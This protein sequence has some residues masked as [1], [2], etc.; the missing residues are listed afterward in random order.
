MVLIIDNIYL[1]Y[2]SYLLNLDI[3]NRKKRSGSNM[4]EVKEIIWIFFVLV[5]FVMYF[6]GLAIFILGDLYFAIFGL[7]SNNERLF[8]FLGGTPY[9]RHIFY[10]VI[11]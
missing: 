9:T 7:T 1:L 10:E 2:Y 4:K 11:E 6:I 3:K 8:N 5:L